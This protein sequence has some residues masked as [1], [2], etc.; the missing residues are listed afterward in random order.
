MRSGFHGFR[1]ARLRPRD[2]EPVA[3]GRGPSGAENPRLQRQVGTL[4]D[5]GSAPSGAES[6]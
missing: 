3:T 6:A 2:A 1:V 5:Y 4:G